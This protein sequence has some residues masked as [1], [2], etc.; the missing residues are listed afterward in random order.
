ML[1]SPIPTSK[2]L[3]SQLLAS[4]HKIQ[5]EDYFRHAEILE[6]ESYENIDAIDLEDDPSQGEE[7]EDI[8]VGE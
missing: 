8:D 3:F 1:Q 4:E 7:S 5:L 2:D 6:E